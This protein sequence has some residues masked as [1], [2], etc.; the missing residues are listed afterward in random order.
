MRIWSGLMALLLL[1]AGAAATDYPINEQP[2]YGGITKTPAMVSADQKFIDAVVQ[3]GYTR[4]KGSDMAVQSGWENFRKGDLATAMKRFNQ[5]W[6]LDPDN[7]DAFDG[8]ASVVLARD[9][10]AAKADSLFQS[11]TD[12]PRRSARLYVDYGRFLLAQKRADAAARKLEMALTFPD[13]DPEA[14]ALLTEAYD[15]VDDRDGACKEARKV[16]GAVSA[17]HR[18]A[19]DTIRAKCPKE[20]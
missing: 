2:L 12:K 14:E 13:V 16:S 17:E 20:V 4:A 10:D 15:A 3:Q 19:V 5:A 7:G 8:F 11:G 6:L 9:A 18:K 1:A